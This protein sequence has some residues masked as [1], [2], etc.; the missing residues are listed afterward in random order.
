MIFHFLKFEQIITLF[1]NRKCKI[2]LLISGRGTI[3]LY[4]EFKVGMDMK[5]SYCLSRKEKKNYI[6]TYHGAKVIKG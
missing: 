5:K 1:V 2:F 4:G 6:P 3:A